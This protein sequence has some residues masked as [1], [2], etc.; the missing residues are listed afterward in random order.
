MALWHGVTTDF[1]HACLRP[2]SERTRKPCL[3]RIA[4]VFCVAQQTCVLTPSF[5]PS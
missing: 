2:S 5:T 4:T 3:D 1:P